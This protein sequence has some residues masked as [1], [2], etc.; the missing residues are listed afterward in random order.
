MKRSA[1][2]FLSVAALTLADA[3]VWAQGKTAWLH[4]RVEEPRKESK[5]RVNLPLT[6]VEVALSMAPEKIVSGGHI[7]LGD[8]G[9][10]LSMADLRQLWKGLRE[11]GE[12]E[13]V[14]VED[15]NETVN[16]RREGDRIRVRAEKAAGKDSR[17]ETVHVDLPVAVVDAALAGEGQEID[18]R[19]ALAQLQKQRGD[20]VRVD[21]GDSQVRIW[22]D[23]QQ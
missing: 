11:T 4:V 8:H 18:I 7:H 23:E 20:I 2:I 15:K 9:H 10:K 17:K 5:V 19:G 13:I 16:V 21:D 1:F 12:A 22:I 3:P 14:S 6:V